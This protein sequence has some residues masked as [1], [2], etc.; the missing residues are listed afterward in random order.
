MQHAPK[1]A[2]TPYEQSALGDAVSAAISPYRTPVSSLV[3][4][5]TRS[6]APLD[7]EP[8]NPQNPQSLGDTP[9]V[10]TH[11]LWRI[12]AALGHTA[13][14]TVGRVRRRDLRRLTMRP[15]RSVADIARLD[16]WEVDETVRGLEPKYGFAGV[17][18]GLAAGAF[19]VRG[20]A[21]G[22]PLLAWLA[23]RQ[24][25]EYGIRYG[26][27]LN[28]PDERAFA[29][30][31]FVSALCPN[32]LPRE[33]EA[34]DLARVTE[35]AKRVSRFAGLLDAAR[36]LLRRVLR[37]KK[38]T[39]RAAVVVLGVAAASYN[40]WFLSGVARMAALAYRERFIARKHRMSLAELA[41]IESTIEPV[42]P[43]GIMSSERSEA[44]P[45]GPFDRRDEARPASSR[46]DGAR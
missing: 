16:L 46:S 12:L 37:P 8:Q 2:L 38:K 32:R 4:V 31:I 9:D 21:L 26:F 19:G 41:E 27:D 10:V 1:P 33:V 28:D 18:L 15:M 7:A 29:T 3:H 22:K 11:G 43:S 5:M 25:S 30:Q 42:P 35:A 24:I 20:L 45:P 6:N 44:C 34:A 13:T 17:L 40:A 23:M 36:G 39:A 14:K